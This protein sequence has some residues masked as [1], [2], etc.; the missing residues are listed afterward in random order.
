MAQ[1]TMENLDI[2]PSEA[3]EIARDEILAASGSNFDANR[4]STR[5]KAVPATYAEPDALQEPPKKTPKHAKQM[6]RKQKEMNAEAA[7]AIAESKAAAAKA[8]DQSIDL[9][10]IDRQDAITSTAKDVAAKQFD[11]KLAA[12]A[13]AD[14]KKKEKEARK[15]TKNLVRDG[16][17]KQNNLPNQSQPK[18]RTQHTGQSLYMKRS[19][20]MVTMKKQNKPNPNPKGNQRGGLERKQRAAAKQLKLCMT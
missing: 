1:K 5:K 10:C 20:L 16:L 19:S 11:K 2:Q 15:V 7:R 6:S 4:S 9:R 17:R 14:A 3:I 12:K 13:E 8:K 18:A